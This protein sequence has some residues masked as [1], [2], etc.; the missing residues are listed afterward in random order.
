MRLHWRNFLAVGPNQPLSS[1]SR[2]II[3]PVCHQVMCKAATTVYAYMLYWTVLAGR[4]MLEDPILEDAPIT[5]PP[6]PARLGG[7]TRRLPALTQHHTWMQD[8]SSSLHRCASTFLKQSQPFSHYLLYK[9]ARDNHLQFCTAFRSCVSP[10]TGEE[11]FTESTKSPWQHWCLQE[12]IKKLLKSI[13]KL[14]IQSGSQDVT[15]FA[16]SKR[17]THSQ[18]SNE[19]MWCARNK[20]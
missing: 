2:K 20:L 17:E 16:N 10:S 4:G 7:A 5:P 14:S 6:P 11:E 13:K 18:A 8:R 19:R 1:A 3:I 12:S 9:L 15:A